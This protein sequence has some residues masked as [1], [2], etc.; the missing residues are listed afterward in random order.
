MGNYGHVVSYNVRY[1]G[2]QIVGQKRRSAW[3]GRR[4]SGGRT[5]WPLYRDKVQVS[6]GEDG[7]QG[8]IEEVVELCGRGRESFVVVPLRD[9]TAT[10]A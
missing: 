3:R 9:Y 6:G 10:L 4:E 1:Y 5:N 2:L 8:D 7:E